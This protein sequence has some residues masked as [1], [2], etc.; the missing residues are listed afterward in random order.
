MKTF[1]EWHTRR[2]SLAVLTGTGR[3]VTRVLGGCEGD[4]WATVSVFYSP[5]FIPSS[6]LPSFTRALTTP[7][8]KLVCRLIIQTNSVA[9]SPLLPLPFPHHHEVPRCHFSCC[10]SRRCSVR[11]SI[12][13]SPPDFL[14]RSLFIINSFL[15]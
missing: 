14:K 3:H 13:P 11:M 6:F 7:L 1:L 15:L 4:E 10:H 8:D 5:S 12:L 2:L 9:L